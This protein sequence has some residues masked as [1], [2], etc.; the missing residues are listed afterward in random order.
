M[1]T[2]DEILAGYAAQQYTAEQAKALILEHVDAHADLCEFAGR[3]MQGML[4]TGIRFPSKDAMAAEAFD[5]GQCMVACARERR[6][7]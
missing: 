4:S 1:L 7:Q 6:G 3:V 5:I 2:I